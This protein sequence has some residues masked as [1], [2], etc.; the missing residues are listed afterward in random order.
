[1]WL[2]M[3]KL[4]YTQPVLHKEHKEFMFILNIHLTYLN[5]DE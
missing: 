1:M 4:E 3:V 5:S 2:M